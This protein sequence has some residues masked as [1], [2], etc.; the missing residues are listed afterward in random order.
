[1]DRDWLT[2]GLANE[3]GKDSW[4]YASVAGK[5]NT[6]ESRFLGG[7]KE[8]GTQLTGQKGGLDIE[9]PRNSPL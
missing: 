1:M 3:V 4:D 6:E 5:E 2:L 8:E 7:R 9:G